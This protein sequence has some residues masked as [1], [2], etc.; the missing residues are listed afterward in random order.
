[1]AAKVIEID[2][3][4]T[5]SVK[6]AIKELKQYKRYLEKQFVHDFLNALADYICQDID[7]RYGE[8]DFANHNLDLREEIDPATSHFV[9]DNLVE[10]TKDGKG[11]A[12]IEFGA[13]VFANDSIYKDFGF[14][15][16]SYSVEHEQTFQKWFNSEGKLY[17]LNGQYKYNQESANAF[18][19]VLNHLDEY[20]I[21]ALDEVKR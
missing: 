15:P 3:Y 8:I 14:E 20:I 7:G 13:G 11:I 2:P 9:E 18:D 1:M 6:K 5:R 16:G 10:I 4:S 17:S 12:F 21:M 19:R